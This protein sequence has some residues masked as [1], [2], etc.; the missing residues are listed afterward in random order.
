MNAPLPP[1][2]AERLQTLREYNI[3]DTPPEVAFERITALAAQ[4]FHVPISLVSLVDADRQWFK[5]CFGVDM[6]QTSR[7]MSFCAHAILSD[8]VMAVPDAT[9]DRASS[10]MPW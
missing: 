3:L 7:E 9:A 8:Q 1:N 6:R 2:E 10:I 5:A 4:V